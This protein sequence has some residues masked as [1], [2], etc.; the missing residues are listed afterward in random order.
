VLEDVETYGLLER[1]GSY[2]Y[3]M[4]GSDEIDGDIAQLC[5]MKYY[6][7]SWFD[8]ILAYNDEYDAA[9]A[10][11]AM[12]YNETLMNSCINGEGWT[13]FAED[14]ELGTLLGVRSSPSYFFDNNTLPSS[15]MVYTYGAAGVLCTMHP[16]L[17]GCEDVDTIEVSQSAGSC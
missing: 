2:Y 16:E 9:S 5:A 17:S 13:L 12:G 11:T 15:S 6:N 1:N 4:H 8:F 14:L 10:I 3:S 7:S